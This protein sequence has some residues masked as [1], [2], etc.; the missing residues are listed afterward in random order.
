[1]PQVKRVVYIHGN[2]IAEFQPDK[3]VHIGD[4]FLVN[5][6]SKTKV[7]GMP[8]LPAGHSPA[9]LMAGKISS[10][11]TLTPIQRFRRP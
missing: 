6:Q 7:L 4:L 5:G 1:M 3:I 9:F 11:D 10:G 8:M 2:S